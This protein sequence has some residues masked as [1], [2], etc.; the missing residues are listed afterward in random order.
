MSQI[1]INATTLGYT[2]RETNT[3]WTSGTAY[4]GQY[5]GHSGSRVGALIF[6]N[7]R[8]VD[9]TAQVIS[10]ITVSLTFGSSGASRAKEIS[11]YT[12]T[13][14]S[15]GG[16]GTNMKGTYLGKFSSGGTAYNATRQIELSD[17]SYADVFANIVAYLQSDS[18]IN[19]FVVYNGQTIAAT[20]TY[21]KD[22]AAITAASLIIDYEVAGSTGTVTSTTTPP[23]LGDS[24]TL[25]ITPATV[26]A[27]QT[28][29]HKVQWAMGEETS[30]VTTLAEGVTTSTYTLPTAWA[31]EIT[32]GH[33]GVAKC[34]LTT[35]VDGN[36]R[37]ER[38]IEF[39]VQLPSSYAPTFSY[40]AVA[41]GRSSDTSTY[42]QYVDKATIT[43]TN[44]T[45]QYG[46]TIASYNIVSA[47]GTETASSSTSSL[48]TPLFQVSGSHSY[49]LTVTDS[50]GVSTSQTVTIS[51]TALPAPTIT[52]FRVARYA[53]RYNDQHQ[54]EYYESTSG[55][56]VWVTI[57]A[58]I[59]TAL[60]RNTPTAYI[61]YA[62]VD[63][64]ISTGTTVNLTWPSGSA[65]Y[66]TSTND[67]TIITAT[68]PITSAYAFELHV[69]DGGHD[70][71]S[72]TRVEK[73]SPA[74]HVAGTGYGVGVGKYSD[75]TS[76][77]PKFQVAWKTE[78]DDDLYVAQEVHAAGGIY[79]ENDVRVD[80]PSY[81]A[82]YGQEIQTFNSN[83][84]YYYTD[85]QTSAP[86]YPVVKRCLNMVF[87]TGECKPTQALTF[88]SVSDE[89]VMFTLPSG[90]RP[91]KTVYGVMQG[92]GTRE[93]LMSITESG[94]V[95]ISR[96]RYG[97]S[98]ENLATT[99]F[100]PFTITFMTT[101]TAPSA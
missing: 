71:I 61:K 60:G 30:S 78:M 40:T 70:V 92:S 34:I 58:S 7:L 3:S 77:T 99:S 32:V 53:S 101:D 79:G 1:T 2:T 72:R 88:S 97:T 26:S 10:K 17:S 33:T 25:T 69:V 51:V 36:D 4:Q 62:T 100:L 27:G 15:L 43:I 82:L 46:A 13:R 85:S 41:T 89:Y 11:M 18:T 12:G 98:Y 80:D 31:S 48:T 59:T 94:D 74:I 84:T 9:W 42:Y 23:H 68:I 57:S 22:Y 91:L 67:R 8:S 86:I 76:A 66:T 19:T 35:V 5:T 14:N 45:A 63:V 50:R 39:T 38:E 6:N 93:W 96:Y 44:A 54:I 90:Y 29:T 64:D 65:T 95:I 81:W 37:A 21:T 55:D 52:T 56:H 49:V 75:G 24:V 87:L 47:S 28:L 20:Q 83:F 16:S 73:G